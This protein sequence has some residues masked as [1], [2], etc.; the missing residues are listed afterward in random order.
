[1][2]IFL[3]SIPFSAACDLPT[4]SIFRIRLPARFSLNVICKMAE[5]MGFPEI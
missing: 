1:M 4:T 5:S 2:T 3:A